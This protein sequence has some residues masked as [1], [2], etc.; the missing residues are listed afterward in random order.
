AAAAGEL[1]RSRAEGVRV[2]WVEVETD[3]G[4]TVLVAGV[5]GLASGTVVWWR[6]DLCSGAFAYLGVGF[7]IIL[8][9]QFWL[10]AWLPT[11]ARRAAHRVLTWF[12]EQCPGE[13]VEGVAVRAVEPGRFV[14]AV[15]HGFGRPT[16]R[17]YFAITRSAPS[18]ITELPVEDWWPRGR[19]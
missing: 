2:A 3:A 11:D 9:R 12:R 17:R 7:A 18:E 10:Q 4:P 16:P 5:L 1:G 13:R 6:A 14:F 15:R 19:K 8:G